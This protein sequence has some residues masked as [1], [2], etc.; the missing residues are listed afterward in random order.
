LY[1][2][3]QNEKSGSMVQYSK[4]KILVADDFEM[5]KKFHSYIIKMYG[6]EVGTAENGAIALEKLLVEDGYM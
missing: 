3:D 4:K 5:V 2:P 1:I 6:Y